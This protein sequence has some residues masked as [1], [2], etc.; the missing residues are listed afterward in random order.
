MTEQV[1]RAPVVDSLVCS[2]GVVVL[3]EDHRVLALGPAASVIWGALD[4]GARTVSELADELVAAYGPPEDGDAVG[5]TR[6]V[7]T[8][9]VGDGIL[10]VADSAK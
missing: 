6:S 8:V 1:E 9:L 2:D 7:V 10:R 4:A 5:A 3:L